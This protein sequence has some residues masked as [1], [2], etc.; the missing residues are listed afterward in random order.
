MRNQLRRY[1]V[2]AVRAR[3]RESRTRNGED[4][5]FIAA[6]DHLLDPDVLTIGFARRMATYKRMSLII[7]DPERTARSLTNDERPVQF[8]LAGK[9]HPFDNE[10]KRNFQ[11][12]ARWKRPIEHLGRIV[13]LE[14]YEVALARF[15]VQGCDVWLNLPR[16]PLE[17]SGTSGQKVIANGG[18]N[19]SI[20]DGWWC[21]GLR[22]TATAG[23]S[24]PS[25][26]TAT[27]RRRTTPTRRR[28]TACSRT[29]SCRSSTS[30]TS[31]ASRAA[32]WRACARRCARCCRS[33]TPIAWC[34]N[35]RAR[36][37]AAAVTHGDG[38]SHGRAHGLCRGAF[39]RGKALCGYGSS[40]YT[41]GR[42]DF[43]CSAVCVP[44][45]WA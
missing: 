5:D 8:V 37:I 3:A 42:E 20:L 15:L 30:A 35:T 7:H 19:C 29:R 39:L 17:A 14:N 34:S 41:F 22:K 33:S 2:A 4:P 21:E 32:G 6:A 9:A 44:S 45:S 12:L 31:A 36:C 23:R 10:A 40:R 27:P 38:R 18:L 24:A 16:R 11:E 43:P 28:S 25:S 1:L 26:T 13:Y